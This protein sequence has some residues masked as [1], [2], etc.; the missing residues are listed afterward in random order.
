MILNPSTSELLDLPKAKAK[1]AA[2]AAEAEAAKAKAKAKAAA[3]AAAPVDF[4]GRKKARKER[5]APAS[6]ASET[7]LGTLQDLSA[8]F[9]D[10]GLHHC[11]GGWKFRDWIPKAKYVSLVGDFNGW[12][13]TATPLT[14]AEKGDIWSCFIGAPMNAALTK[15]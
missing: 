5:A 13:P 8:I 11:N 1:A 2:K 10:F 15:G 9:K 14:K 12:D 3:K 7:K 6:G 4:E